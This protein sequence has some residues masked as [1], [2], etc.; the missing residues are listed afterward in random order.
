LESK[1]GF[2]FLISRVIYNNSD[3][4]A[5]AILGL[6]PPSAYSMGEITEP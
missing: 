3:Q 2:N 5:S 4:G 1:K 6:K